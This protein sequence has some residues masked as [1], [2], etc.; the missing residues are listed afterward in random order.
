MSSG[1]E[2]DLA[3]REVFV[4]AK[5]L[6][7]IVQIGPKLFLGRLS[8]CGNVLGDEL[9][10][11]P[12]TLAD[13]SIVAIEPEGQSLAVIN[14]FANV[15]SKQAL[16][17]IR[18]GWPLMRAGESIL[19]MF[20]L[21]RRDNYLACVATRPLVHQIRGEQQQR[22]EDQEVNKRFSQKLFE[23]GLNAVSSRACTKSAKCKLAPAPSSELP[24]AS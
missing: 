12:Q 18:I 4:D 10:L 5:F 2:I 24:W 6:R 20:H 14:L 13:G 16:Q 23:H 19:E 17:F 22:P 21:S 3:K 11:L 8:L 9:H 1:I 15:I 7:V